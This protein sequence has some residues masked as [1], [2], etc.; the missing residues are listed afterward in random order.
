MVLMELRKIL[1]FSLEWPLLRKVWTG[2]IA[3]CG[4]GRKEGDSLI[5]AMDA[6]EYTMY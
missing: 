6:N 3:Q 4:K 5:M 2:Y 1:E